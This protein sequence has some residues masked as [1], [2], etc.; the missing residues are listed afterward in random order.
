MGTLTYSQHFRP[1]DKQD[2]SSKNRKAAF[3]TAFLRTPKGSCSI[4]GVSYNTW[5]FTRATITRA[6]KLPDMADRMKIQQS[7]P[8]RDWLTGTSIIMRRVTYYKHSRSARKTT[9]TTTKQT[10][11]QES[12]SIYTRRRREVGGR[13]ICQDTYLYPGGVK[14][15]ETAEM[16]PQTA[17]QPTNLYTFPS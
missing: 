9:I 16:K 10:N 7:D 2:P 4:A 3:F 8:G 11:K 13:Q 5:I 12:A 14:K 1:E 17:H 6:D 15:R